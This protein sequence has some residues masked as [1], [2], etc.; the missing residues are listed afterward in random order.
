V[1]DLGCGGLFEMTYLDLRMSL[2]KL[3]GLIAV[4]SMVAQESQT[5]S[6]R[7]WHTLKDINTETWELLPIT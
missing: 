6:S 4:L 3:G 2:L 1:S 7:N 5:S